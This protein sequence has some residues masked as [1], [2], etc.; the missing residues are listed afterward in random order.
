VDRE[1]SFNTYFAIIKRYDLWSWSQASLRLD[2]D[3]LFQNVT[4]KGKAMLDVGAGSGLFSLY[5]AMSGAKPVVSLEPE[6]AG[7]TEGISARLRQLSLAFPNRIIVK[8]SAFQEFDPGMQTFDII[9]LHNS[10]NHL[11]EEACISLQ[12]SEDAKHKYSAIF[13]KLSKLAAPGA[14]LII[15][16]CSNH[17]LFRLL[18]LYNPFAPRIRWHK[19]QSPKFWSSMLMQFGFVNSKIR[20]TPVTRFGKA[21]ELLSGNW[22]ISY[23]TKSHFCLTMDRR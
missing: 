9:L 6:L 15:C 14:K 20:W 1:E 13:H 12:Y 18:H 19:H 8:D 22:L 21:G 10:I 2:L 4:F 5:G 17:N 16:D 7:S 11:D 23:C 3:Y